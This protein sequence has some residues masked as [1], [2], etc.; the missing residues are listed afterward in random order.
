MRIQVAIGCVG[1]FL[2]ATVAPASGQRHINLN[3]G[4]SYAEALGGQFGI[5]ARLGF[6]PSKRPVDL[7]VGGDYFFASCREDCSLW[8]WRI[9]A[10]LHPSNPSSYPFLSAAFGGRELKRGEESWNR[11]GV[12]V[13]AG[14][15]FTVGKFRI[16]AEIARE[17]LG[18]E[19][20]QWVIRLGTG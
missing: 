1:A 17:F 20:D 9:G 19:L 12:S 10:H 13:G 8:G 2:L 5:E 16:Q 15:R 3:L 4:G 18:K 7:F 14:Y 11:S 6:Y